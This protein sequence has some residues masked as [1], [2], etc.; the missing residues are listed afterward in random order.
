VILIV[1]SGYDNDTINICQH[2]LGKTITPITNQDVY[3]TSSQEVDGNLS[4]NSRLR[5]KTHHPTSPVVPECEVMDNDSSQCAY[6]ALSNQN[7]LG[8]SPSAPQQE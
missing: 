7:K 4:P 8:S 2:I 5:S 1:F 6:L 3:S